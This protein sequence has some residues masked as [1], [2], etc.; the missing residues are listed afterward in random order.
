[1]LVS[2]G[3]RVDPNFLGFR[4]FV[5]LG[6]CWLQGTFSTLRSIAQQEGLAGIY[7]GIGPTILTN[8]PFSA[9]YYM[10][11][12]GLKQRLQSVRPKP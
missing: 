1:M 3:K 5:S 10:F 4:V 11:Y 8:A 9:L 6:L 7:R 12:T 2:L